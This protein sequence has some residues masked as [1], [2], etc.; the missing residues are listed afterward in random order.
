MV[1]DGRWP[2]ECAGGHRPAT[3]VLDLEEPPGFPVSPQSQFVP[4]KAARIM[5]GH[6]FTTGG[7]ESH[8]FRGTDPIP[9]NRI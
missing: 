6:R 3:H 1:D 2:L 5:A 7:R 4:V 8:A 9:T